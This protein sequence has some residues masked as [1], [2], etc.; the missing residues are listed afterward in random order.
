MTRRIFASLTAFAAL[1]LTPLTV[2]AR[3]VIVPDCG[4]GRHMLIV[5]GKSD[6]Q[7]GGACA[8]A[9]HAMSER[10][11]KSPGTRKACC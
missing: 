7:G 3:V 2:D 8:K 11:G 4:G 6:D 10:R 5:P 1:A 9:C